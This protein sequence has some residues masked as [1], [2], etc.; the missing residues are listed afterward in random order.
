MKV[1]IDQN[2][3]FCF[4][5]IN[6][7]KKAEEN[8][9]N[10]EYLYC[11]GDIVHNDM[12]ISRL[13]KLG[14]RTID[15]QQFLTLKNCKVLL[16]AHGEPPSTYEHARNNNIELI[17]ATCPVVLKL[18]QRIKKA[19]ED[20]R[21]KEGQIVI[22]GKKGHAEVTGLNGQTGN[23]AI[24]IE[25]ELD[26]TQIDPEKP[27]I[28][29]SQTT[30]PLD[31]FYRLSGKI[32]EKAQASTEIKDTICRQV[33]NRVPQLKTFA[34]HHDVIIFVGGKKSSNA[35]ML[36]DICKQTNPNSYFV[37]ATNEIET[38]WFENCETVGISGATSTPQWLMEEIAE[39]VR[40][41]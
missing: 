14:L 1:V 35:K 19:H 40:Q 9:K 30:K 31:E 4:G 21:Q 16:R 26:L 13:E 18:Q 17:D 5:V 29:F 7:I 3:G 34:S 37:S 10:D 39:K 24:L 41:M 11:L 20:M 2:S 27:L 12:E 25:N 36:F 15:H 33:A 22:F 23:N 38:G 6:A 28:M 8:L 32:Q